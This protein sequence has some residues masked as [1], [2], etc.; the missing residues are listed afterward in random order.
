MLANYHE[1]SIIWDT[2]PKIWWY[3]ATYHQLELHMY[4]RV[5]QALKIQISYMRWSR[6]LLLSYLVRWIL[7]LSI[8]CMA[9]RRTTLAQ[10]TEEERPLPALWTFLCDMQASFQS[11]WFQ[12]YKPSRGHQWRTRVKGNVAFKV[13]TLSSTL[14]LHFACKKKW[15]EVQLYV[16]LRAVVNSKAGDTGT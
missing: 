5:K 2:K 8:Q 15:P 4:N 16:D 14:I 6:C 3:I 9:S 1:P 12:F 13:R 7:S 11:E 10:L